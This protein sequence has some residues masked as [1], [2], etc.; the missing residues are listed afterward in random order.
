MN[1]H[2]WGLEDVHLITNVVLRGKVSSRANLI[3]FDGGEL[4]VRPLSSH[5]G[6]L[7]LTEVTPLY[8]PG[9]IAPIF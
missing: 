2:G 9:V 7:A 4:P 3:K 6:C 1:L 8:E 5:T